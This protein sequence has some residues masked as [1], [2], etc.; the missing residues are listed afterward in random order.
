MI[1]QTTCWEYCGKNLNSEQRAALLYSFSRDGAFT[2]SLHIYERL[3]FELRSLDL[4]KCVVPYPICAFEITPEGRRV[5]MKILE[6]HGITQQ[7]NH[8]CQLNR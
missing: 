3:A 6:T 1:S 8:Q 4:W 2:V 5:A 7:E